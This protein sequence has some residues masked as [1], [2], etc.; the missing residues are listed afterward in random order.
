MS[1]QSNAIKAFHEENGNEYVV[2][3]D[4]WILFANGAK[5]ENCTFC[6]LV[7]PPKDPYQLAKLQVK[8]H[9]TLFERAR[10][11]YDQKFEYAQQWAK[12]SARRGESPPPPSMLEEVKEL[13]KLVKKHQKQLA[14]AEAHL[15]DVTPDHLKRS[16]DEAF[17]QRDQER[18][19]AFVRQ[20]NSLK[21]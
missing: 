10:E 8:Y 9:R 16:V 18:T 3:D 5:R 14:E 13:R 4:G 6:A 7:D 11:Q 20:L 12:A 17:K 2:L 1:A 15:E 19:A 21:I